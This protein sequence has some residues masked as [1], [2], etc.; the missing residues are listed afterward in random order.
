M[1]R[2]SDSTESFDRYRWQFSDIA[3]ISEL[4]LGS[5]AANGQQTAGGQGRRLTEQMQHELQE[6]K[7]AAEMKAMEN[8]LNEMKDEMRMKDMKDEQRADEMKNEMRE[9]KGLLQQLLADK[10]EK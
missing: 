1:F 8:N 4:G 5:S 7:H 3:T 9:L 6:R 10:V 2:L